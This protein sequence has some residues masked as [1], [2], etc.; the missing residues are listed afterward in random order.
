LLL[1]VENIVG[2]VNQLSDLVLDAVEDAVNSF[3]RASNLFKIRSKNLLEFLKNL[4]GLEDVTED[5]DH[6]ERLREDVL[7][8][9]EL[10]TVHGVG[11][12][13]LSLGLIVP[14][15]PLS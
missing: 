15:F 13:N 8:V 3:S 7:S 9:R 12:F 10:P 2:E 4:A 1:D 11:K 14:F 6:V 5:G